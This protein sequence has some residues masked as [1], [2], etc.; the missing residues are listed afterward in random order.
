M[1]ARAGILSL[2]ALA[3]GLLLAPAAGHAASAAAKE[4][5]T[6]QA[7]VDRTRI[8][9]SDRVEVGFQ[10]TGSQSGENFRPPDFRDFT[11]LS[12]P[13]QSTNFQMINGAVST[14][15]T[16]GYILQP[17]REGDLV[18][19]PATI[20][21]RGKR[22]STGPVT[23]NVGKAPP[24]SARPNA[25]A[26]TDDVAA[27][28]G[29]NLF[30]R[31]ELDKR[32]AWQGEQITATYKIYTRVN[33]VNY[34]LSKV[35]SYTGFWSEELDVPQQV[36]LATETFE[37]KQYR[38]GVLKKVALF[39]QRSGTLDLGPMDIECVVQVQTRRKSNDIFDQFFNDPFF[40]NARNVNYTVSTRPEKI[41]VRPLPSDGVPPGFGGAVGKFSMEAWADREQV[42]ENE[43]VT[44]RVKIS[45]TG[46]IKLL[47]APALKFPADF[48]IYD[49]KISDQGSKGKTVVSGVRTFEYLLIPRHAGE[50]RIPAV[51]FSY[52]DPS[53]R[54]YATLR[55]GEFVISVSKGSDKG[56]TIA[57]GSG[58]SREDVRLLGE[59]I[60]FIRSDDVTLSKRGDRF[61]G[62][63]FFFVMAASPVA[64]FA[65]F[66]VVMRRRERV[67]GDV[68]GLRA[69]KARNIA[70]RRLAKAKELLS[71]G[72]SEAFHT[73]VSKALWGYCADKLGF[74]QADLGL[75]AICG[76][77]GAR[78]AK[79][80]SVSALSAII[81]RCDF[82][83][84]APDQD[85]R[86]MGE[87]YSGAE[88]LIQD[89]EQELR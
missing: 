88:K 72:D 39:A 76:G 27:Q 51:A 36:Q 24:Q 77:L 37:G 86:G 26:Q 55:S 59:D 17:R 32:T 3:A 12:G 65:L 19:G 82:A 8:T 31:V 63:P 49:P 83:R 64:F 10:L 18:I 40:G 30:L 62:S 14:S 89:L 50:Q 69:R 38:V 54:E 20:E 44:F 43:P 80:E 48:D 67:L 11:V 45:G 5:V 84:F 58:L 13:N 78:G 7:T 15:V 75:D 23:I 29:E 60:R 41:T 81:S 47:E 52:F 87:T 85:H 79:P 68:A 61:A 21:L 74:T 57:Q 56:G 1:V 71:S 53:R 33:V 9:L 4:D 28:I 73:E 6:F 16:F 70:R 22:Y 46:N 66:L 2:L 35:P 25:S 42:A 34:N